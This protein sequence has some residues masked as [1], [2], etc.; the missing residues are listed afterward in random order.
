MPAL[1]FQMG[2][3]KIG[4]VLYV[5]SI[6]ILDKYAG[7]TTHPRVKMYGPK[8]TVIDRRKLEAKT[9]PDA[10][11]GEVKIIPPPPPDEYSDEPSCLELRL[12][13]RASQRQNRMAQ[14]AKSIPM[15]FDPFVFSA[16]DEYVKPRYTNRH[17][18]MMFERAVPDR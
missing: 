4:V 14:S 11:V 9:G 7:C 13:W 17:K 3:M 8:V 2:L 1:S 10:V 18:S 6:L 15:A 5:S 16:W 12:L